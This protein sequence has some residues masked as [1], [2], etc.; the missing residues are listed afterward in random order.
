MTINGKQVRIR[1]TMV[2]F[3]V[4]LSERT[5][6]KITRTW[7]IRHPSHDPKRV[8]LEHNFGVLLLH[9]PAQHDLIMAKLHTTG[10]GTVTT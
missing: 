1:N 7:D 10:Y 2:M 5:N 4:C 8:R 3:M 6:E 9:K